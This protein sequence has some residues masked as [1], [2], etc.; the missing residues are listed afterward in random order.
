M[1]EEVTGA[2][3]ASTPGAFPPHVLRDNALITTTRFS[4]KIEQLKSQPGSSR[5]RAPR[6]V[7]VVI[8]TLMA[9]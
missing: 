9:R 7:N 5:R 1:S 4:D 6:P 2:M 3:T 8:M